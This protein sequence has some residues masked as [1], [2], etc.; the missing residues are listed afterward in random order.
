MLLLKSAIDLRTGT[1]RK[2]WNL[3]SSTGWG[4]VQQMNAHL[5][6]K[7]IAI[8]KNKNWIAVATG[9]G[10]I[11]ILDYNTGNIRYTWKP[12]DSLIKVSLFLTFS[13]NLHQLTIY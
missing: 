1:I 6:V 11:S 3:P 4:I 9:S 12:Y 7:S 5:A 10:S 2:E 8:S 13:P